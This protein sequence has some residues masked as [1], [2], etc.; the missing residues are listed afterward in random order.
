MEV[1]AVGLGAVAALAACCGI[2]LLLA[3]GAMLIGRGKRGAKAGAASDRKRSA[4]EACCEAPAS[5]AKGAAALLSG[6]R[7]LKAKS[8][9]ALG[10]TRP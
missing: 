5:L 4:L 3:G 2:P 6:K 9:D 8:P 7:R 1:S 10:R